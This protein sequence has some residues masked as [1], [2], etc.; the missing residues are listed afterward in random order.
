MDKKVGDKKLSTWAKGS[1]FTYSGSVQE[2]VQIFYGTKPFRQEISKEQFSKMLQH[3]NGT[4]VDIGTSRTDRS[5]E[6]LGYWLGK[7]IC[8]RAIASYVGAILVDE[9]FARR[10][11]NLIEFI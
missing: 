6:S 4:T 3:F 2:G 7:Y 9:G 11:K 5:P 8:E 10:R 1:T